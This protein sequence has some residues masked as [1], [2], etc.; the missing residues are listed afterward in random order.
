MPLTV[1]IDGPRSEMDSDI[2]KRILD[3]LK[4]FDNLDIV[5]REENY[6]LYK[7][8]K[9]ALDFELARHDW[10]IVLE[11]DLK[12]RDDFITETLAAIEFSHGLEKIFS[13]CAFTEYRDQYFV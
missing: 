8:I 10:V 13:V 9:F 6:G 1:Y 2:Q 11:D 3:D 12:I 7:N 4:H 5:Y